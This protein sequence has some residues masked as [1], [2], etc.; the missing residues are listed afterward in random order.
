[1]EAVI[2]NFVIH[3]HHSGA[4]LPHNINSCKYNYQPQNGYYEVPELPGI[5]QELMEETIKLSEKV[6]IK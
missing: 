1:M 4:L 2:P 6:I 5:G 3:E